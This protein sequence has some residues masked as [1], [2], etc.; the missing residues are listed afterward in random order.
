MEYYRNEVTKLASSWVGLKESDGSYKKI[1]DIYN[2]QKSFPR[3]TKMQYNWAWCAATWSALAIKLGYTS[4][5]PVEISCSYLIYKAK[6]MGIWQEND[7]YVPKPGDAILYDWDDTGI[8]DNFGEPDHIG[9]VETVCKDA[10]YF[11]VIEG[12]YQD[13]VKRRTISIN[14]KFIRGFITP[15]YTKDKNLSIESDATPGKE[16]EKSPHTV[17]HEIIA[18]GWGT[19]NS[20]KKRLEESGYIYKEV[21]GIVNDILNGGVCKACKSSDLKQ[22]VNKVVKASAIAKKYSYKLSGQYITTA[23]LYC[24]NDVGT[25]KKAL[26]LIPKGATVLCDGKYGEDG[27]ST[28][29][30]LVTC[31]L[32]GIQYSGFSSSEYLRKI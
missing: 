21:Q 5:M 4:I 3:G 11:I 25:N 30:L 32:D 10:G 31:V 9:I 14:G 8:G 16:L 12:N 28:K 1:I 2:S 24:R 22:T 27:K 13:A 26:C 7:G 19:G 17:A 20:R 6:E 18:G 29:W 15:K 23:A